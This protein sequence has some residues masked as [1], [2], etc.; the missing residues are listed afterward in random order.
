MRTFYFLAEKISYTFAVAFITIFGGWVGAVF[1]FYLGTSYTLIYY[2]IIIEDVLRWLPLCVV[3]PTI[4]HYLHFG[5]LT[6]I[7]IPAWQKTLRII[8]KNIKRDKIKEDISDV[9]LTELYNALCDIPIWNGL[10]AGMYGT[11]CGLLVMGFFYLDHHLSGTYMPVLMKVLLRMGVVAVTI[12]VLLYSISTYL[13]TEILT[14]RE[15]ARCFNEL[16][17]R[18][19]L[20]KPRVLVNLRVKFSFFVI[21]MLISLLTFAALTQKSIFYGDYNILVSVTYILISIIAAIFLMFFNTRSILQILREM[22]R[23]AGTISSGGEAEFGLHS[24]D[25]EFANIEFSVLEMS[26]EILEFRKNLEQQVE[27]RTLELQNVLTDLKE[28]D[29]LIQKQLDMASIIQRSILPGHI[30]EWLEIKFSIRYI[31]MEKIGGDFYDVYQLRDNKMGLLIADVSGHGIPAALVTTMAKIAFGNACAKYDSPRRIFQEVNQNILDHVKTQDY[32]T[33]FFLVIDD[34]YNVTYA[35]A[36]HQKALLVRTEQGKV[37]QLD[38]NGL[39]IGAIEEARETYEEKTTRLNYGDKIILYTDGIPEATNLA[40]EEYSNERLEEVILKNRHL[41]LDDFASFIIEDVQRFVGNA[42]VEDDITLIVLELVRDEAVDLIKKS[43]KLVSEQKIYEAIE[44]LERGLTIFKDNRKLMY[45][46]AKYYFKVNN[47][48]KTVEYT[49]NYLKQDKTNKYVYY[50][51]GAAFYQMFDYKNAAEYLENAVR[52]D[53]NF[54]NAHFALGMVYKKKGDR[55]EA[56]RSF[57]RV[58]ALEPDNKIA[59][60]ELATLRK[61]K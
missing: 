6:P 49:G 24:L 9:E 28:R 8:N 39:F 18:G 57:E 29:D 58:L 47:Y 11:M 34:E 45:N 55:T 16:F 4:L 43:Q 33:A 60:Y 10:A 50:L 23:V 59:Q 25:S 36:S 44:I 7:K 30:D 19:V 61:T 42:P 3:I 2:D 1:G 27:Q 13:I 56:L 31:A 21:L 46:L 14:S 17:R 38:T 32:L 52:I 37:E 15:R 53:P 20:K 22:G 51:G 41:S 48:G 40:R 26:K 12:V 5:I 54:V 35:N